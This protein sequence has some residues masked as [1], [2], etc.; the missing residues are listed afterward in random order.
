MS[1]ADRIAMLAIMGARIT[2]AKDGEHLIVVGPDVVVQAAAPVLRLY[3]DELIAC[4]RTTM[5]KDVAA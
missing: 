1:P 5:V 3:R 2:V 4:L